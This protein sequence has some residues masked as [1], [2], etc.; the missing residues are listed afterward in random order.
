MPVMQIKYTQKAIDDLQ[1]VFSYIALDNKLTAKR[2][3]NKLKSKIELLSITPLMG[4]DCRKKGIDL[5][6]R[7]LI[8]ENYLIFYQISGDDLI[9]Y[10]V[11][12][13]ALNDGCHPKIN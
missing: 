6:G 12:H 11:L 3:I 2:Y 8:F 10:R 1:E 4:V 13:S 7:L 5:D 9:I